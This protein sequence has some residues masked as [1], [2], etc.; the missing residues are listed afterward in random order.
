MKFMAKAHTNMDITKM[1]MKMKM[2]TTTTTTIF[3]A[4][5]LVMKS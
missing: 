1:K 4:W 2:K 3:E 5:S